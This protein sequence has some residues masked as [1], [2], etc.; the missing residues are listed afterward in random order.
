MRISYVFLKNEEKENPP[1]DLM[2]FRRKAT[3]ISAGC[4]RDGKKDCNLE[5]TATVRC[6]VLYVKAMMS[7]VVWIVAG[8]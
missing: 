1:L 2:K 5:S 3:G 6:M 4:Q 8:L 7:W